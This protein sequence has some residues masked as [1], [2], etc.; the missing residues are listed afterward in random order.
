M[1]A[2]IAIRS[3][4]SSRW[5]LVGLIWLSIGIFDGSDTVFSMRAEGHH[6][7]WFNL[8]VTLTL[9]WLPWALAT[10]WIL[11]LGRRHPFRFTSVS[12]WLPHL[13]ACVFVGL[14]FSAWS[15]A[16]EELLNPWL[17]SPA[18]EPFA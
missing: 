16:L 10:P 1:S 7:A 12:G 15:A 8:F 3:L 13:G 18:P 4:P 17:E 6:H 9:S 14:G 5:F 11:D 2:R